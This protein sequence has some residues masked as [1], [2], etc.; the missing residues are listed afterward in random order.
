MIS[1]GLAVDLDLGPT[2]DLVDRAVP[3]IDGQRIRVFRPFADASFK[4]VGLE[5]LKDR[6][7]D[8]LWFDASI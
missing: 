5:I 4:E 2:L 1:P 6:L 7:V 8:M 3:R